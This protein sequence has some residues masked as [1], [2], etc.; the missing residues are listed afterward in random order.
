MIS[1]LLSDPETLD[2]G[3]KNIPR[4]SLRWSTD[5]LPS[6]EKTINT[7]RATS[8]EYLITIHYYPHILHKAV[9]DLEGLRR[10]HPCFFLGE[11]AKPLQYRLD[12]LLSKELL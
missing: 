11:S 3:L 9:D 7:Q 8:L 12:V 4:A 6:T 1:Y 2:Y 5:T 10:S